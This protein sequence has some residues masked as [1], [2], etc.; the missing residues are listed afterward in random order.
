MKPLI[1]ELKEIAE[2]WT[3]GT[4]SHE[5]EDCPEELKASHEATEKAYREAGTQLLEVIKRYEK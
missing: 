1:E 4:E 3:H 5:S 2:N